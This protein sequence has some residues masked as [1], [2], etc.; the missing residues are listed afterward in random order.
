ML[1]DYV[2]FAAR[3]NLGPKVA[4]T[5]PALFETCGKKLGRSARSVMVDATYCNE[6]GEYLA[7]VAKDVA[8]KLEAV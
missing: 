8:G 4:A 6:L 1:H 3:F 7:G 2:V 5:L